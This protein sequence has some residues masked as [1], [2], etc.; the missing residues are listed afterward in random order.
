VGRLAIPLLAGERRQ[1]QQGV[2]QFDVRVQRIERAGGE[3]DA[4]PG[5]VPERAGLGL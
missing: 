4:L 1:V 5:A 3:R 2:R